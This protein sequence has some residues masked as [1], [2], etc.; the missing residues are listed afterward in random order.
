[1]RILDHPRNGHLESSVLTLL[2]REVYVDAR[3][4]RT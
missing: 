2:S 4:A 1:M 3:V